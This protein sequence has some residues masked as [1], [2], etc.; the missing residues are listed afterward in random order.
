MYPSLDDVMTEVAL[1]KVE[2]HVYH[3]QNTVAQSIA[4]R[5]IMDLCLEA[6]RSPGSRVANQ[7]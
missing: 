1:Q 4:T 2:T 7:W 6:E 5:P 3:R